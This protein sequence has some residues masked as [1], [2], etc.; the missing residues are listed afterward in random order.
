MSEQIHEGYGLT[1][2][3]PKGK[4]SL[5]PPLRIIRTGL[6]PPLRLLSLCGAPRSFLAQLPGPRVFYRLFLNPCY[7]GATALN[8]KH[9]G[10]LS[11]S[12]PLQLWVTAV[13]ISS[14]PYTERRHTSV[15]CQPKSLSPFLPSSF[16]G[17]SSMQTQHTISLL[18]LLVTLR[19]WLSLSP[20]L[21]VSCA[22]FVSLLCLVP[23]A[24]SRRKTH[25]SKQATL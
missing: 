11:R 17:R 5:L 2:I 23:S 1:L 18:S 14:L 7:S 15:K 13:I 25:E 3:I 6:D 10:S 21:I 4:E 20:S 12:S 22:F 16:P 19:V 8:T 24:S 9:S